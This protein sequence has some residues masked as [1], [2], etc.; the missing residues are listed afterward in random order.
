MPLLE[1]IF[2]KQLIQVLLHRLVSI[3]TNLTQNN[4]KLFH[5]V[6]RHKCSVTDSVS[7][8]MLR[9][10]TRTRYHRQE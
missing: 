9:L 1:K 7:I 4:A 6:E 8:F 3:N 10:H 2:Q 5:F